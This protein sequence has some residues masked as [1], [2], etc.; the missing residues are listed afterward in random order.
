MTIK[1]KI[2]QYLVFKGVSKRKFT[3]EA[4]LSDGFLKGNGAI[5][6]DKL[7][8]IRSIC[9]DLNLEWLLFD[10]GEMI[11]SP[12]EKTE[13]DKNPIKEVD[14]KTL[15]KLNLLAVN[16]KVDDLGVDFINLKQEF[17]DLIEEKLG[18]AIKNKEV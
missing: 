1:E 3:N 9:P 18:N 2:R 8:V 4:K 16:K 14:E 12:K 10:E 11:V 7:I 15:A 13:L 5:G 17:L 6:A